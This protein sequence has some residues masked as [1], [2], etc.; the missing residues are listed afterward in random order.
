M[1]PVRKRYFVRARCGNCRQEYEI[2]FKIGQR[3]ETG[4]LACTHCG[5]SGALEVSGP[6]IRVMQIGSRWKSTDTFRWQS[7][8]PKAKGGESNEKKAFDVLHN[9]PAS[10]GRMLGD[11]LGTLPG[12]GDSASPA[13]DADR[14]GA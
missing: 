14:L 6:S 13:A 5:C 8:Y 4:T 10:P 9:R 11:S 12:Q 7:T 1:R 2:F 3:T